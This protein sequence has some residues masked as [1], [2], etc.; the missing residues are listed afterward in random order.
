MRKLIATGR[1]LRDGWLMLGLAIILFCLLEAGAR[2]VLLAQG[3]AADS[4]DLRPRAD[5]YADTS[6]LGAYSSEFD[7]SYPLRWRPYVYWRRKPYQGEYINVDSSG[8]RVTPAPKPPAPSSGRALRVFMF[9]GS[10]MWGTGVRDAFTIPA[11]VASE[12]QRDGVNAEV[13]NFGETGYVSTQSLIALLLQ[14]RA[15]SRPDV[16]VFYDGVNDT[17]S[18]Y[19]Q[20]L[21]GLPQNERNRFSEFNLSQAGPA[22]HIRLLLRD[23]A[24]GLATVNLTK[25][26]LRGLGAAGSAPIPSRPDSLTGLVVTT[27]LS[28]MELLQA[29]GEHYHFEPLA[30]WQPTLFQKSWLTKY[31]RFERAKVPEFEAFFE[32]TYSRMKSCTHCDMVHDLSQVFSDWRDPVYVDWMH[33]GE[34]GNAVIARRIAGDI[35]A[36]KAAR[37]AGAGAPTPGRSGAA[38]R[39]P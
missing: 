16:V 8:L 38:G 30:Y 14:L 31:E 26:L 5:T 17:F 15:G 4:T 27:Y 34:R 39:S 37:V 35:L 22:R 32:K 6:W 20:Q 3:W 10:T 7:R 28:N 25:R 18:A 23:I 9:G 29:L 33:L 2:L 13:T 36:T 12:L 21:P 11:L 19:E 24:D 1:L